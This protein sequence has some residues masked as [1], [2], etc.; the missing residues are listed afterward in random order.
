MHI[1]SCTAQVKESI[2]PLAGHNRNYTWTYFPTFWVQYPM[3]IV[4]IIEFLYYLLLIYC[5]VV[6]VATAT[7]YRVD[8][9]TRLWAARYVF[10]TLEGGKG[11]DAA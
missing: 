3:K 4:F 6:I 10:Y 5:T 9:W 1:K 11:C 2:S 8:T 7:I